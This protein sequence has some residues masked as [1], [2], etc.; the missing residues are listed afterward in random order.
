MSEQI[1]D[2][3][4]CGK[5]HETQIMNFGGMPIATCPNLK[6]GEQALIRGPI[7][8]QPFAQ[9]DEELRMKFARN[10][11][12]INLERLVVEAALAVRAAETHRPGDRGIDRLIAA[13]KAFRRAVSALIAAREVENEKS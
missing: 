7:G 2:C 12:I 5:R 4:V 1:V 3:V 9:R 8:S 13:E 6:E 10:S 11:E